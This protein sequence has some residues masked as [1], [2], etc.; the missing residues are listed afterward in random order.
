M[1]TTYP[2]IQK[3]HVTSFS[4]NDEPKLKKTTSCPNLRAVY[5]KAISDQQE[6]EL[7]SD[8]NFL[9][10]SF[11]ENVQRLYL[12][13]KINQLE[14]GVI[15][16]DDEVDLEEKKVAIEEFKKDCLLSCSLGIFDSDLKILNK[17][18]GSSFC[19]GLPKAMRR[20]ALREKINELL[21][22]DLDLIGEIELTPEEIKNHF[23]DFCND[24][25]FDKDYETLIELSGS[26]FVK[27]LLMVYNDEPSENLNTSTPE[28]TSPQ[29]FIDDLLKK[30][31]N[32]NT[33]TSKKPSRQNLED[34]LLKKS[35]NRNT[36]TPKKSSRRKLED[37]LPKISEN[38]NSYTNI[39]EKI[40]PLKLRSPF[41]PQKLGSHFSPLKLGN[42]FS[43][44][45]KF[46]PKVLHFEFT[47]PDRRHEENPNST[48]DIDK[49]SKDLILTDQQ[50][51]ETKV[52]TNSNPESL[53]TKVNP[54]SDKPKRLNK[55]DCGIMK[56]AGAILGLGI[57]VMGALSTTKILLLVGAVVLTFMTVELFKISQQR[58]KIPILNS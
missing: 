28:Q 9:K 35:G 57:F 5:N 32:R 17:L 23:L 38:L 3:N 21:P 46:I 8:T 45:D 24:G 56:I 55:L 49:K 11:R 44:K 40:S 22:N 50:K 16:W 39:S 27:G 30:S 12:M 26:D 18:T 4:S 7:S 53:E 58:K 41:S 42:L 6:S 54:A 51:I 48:N 19:L 33:S 29:K 47:P 2:T 20:F 14:V 43:Q 1:N 52:A 36:I 13:E 25:T 31:G 34:S 15:E 37:A 10:K